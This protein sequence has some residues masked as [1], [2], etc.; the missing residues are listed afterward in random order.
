MVHLGTIPQIT[1]HTEMPIWFMVSSTMLLPKLLVTWRMRAASPQSMPNRMH[2][3]DLLLIACRMP[4]T[5]IELASVN[6]LSGRC[7]SA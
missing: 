5:V 1:E 3:A 2:N 7:G 4:F 6:N